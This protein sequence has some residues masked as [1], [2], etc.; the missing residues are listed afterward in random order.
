MIE[1]HSIEHTH[2]YKENRWNLK[3]GVL[4]PVSCLWYC[5]KVMQDIT[6]QGNW[7]KG[8]QISP[9][10]FLWLHVNLQWPQNEK[11]RKRTEGHKRLLFRLCCAVLNRVWLCVT[12][13]TVALQAS[14][15][16]GI[17][18]ARILEW[19]AISSSRGFSQT[20]D[21]T[22]V[23]YIAGRFFTIW[24]TRE[25]LFRLYYQIWN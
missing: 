14:L 24:A 4:V 15:S 8:T 6:I 1:L 18:Q 16:M 25:A 17:L 7:R 20:R 3:R 19:V 11:F 13:W 10:Y 22:Q 9:Y 2:K 23:S 5:T 12:P 21:P